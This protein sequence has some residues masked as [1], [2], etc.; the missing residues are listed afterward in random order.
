MQVF[1]RDVPVRN[2]MLA[3][4]DQVLVALSEHEVLSMPLH[5]C[6]HPEVRRSCSGCL[7]LRDPY[8]AWDQRR[9]RCV[10]WRREEEEKSDLLWQEL[11]TGRRAECDV[12]SEALLLAGEFETFFFSHLDTLLV[13]TV[14]LYLIW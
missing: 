5:R 13:G 12:L 14:L 9:E 10:E 4:E 3:R 6:D 8:C 11:K 1:P 7:A 2:L